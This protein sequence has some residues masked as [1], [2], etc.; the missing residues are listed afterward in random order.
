M[1]IYSGKAR[2]IDRSEEEDVIRLCK[3]LWQENGIFQM[4]DEK[5]RSML[6]RAFDRQGGILAGIGSKG[7]L[8]GLLFLI[9]SNFWYTEDSHWEELF[10]YVAPE[11][12]KSRNAVELLKFAK[13]CVEESGFPLFIGILS[14]HTTERKEML[15]ER[16]LK[17][18]PNGKFF[19]YTGKK[20]K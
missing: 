3:M 12:R 20:D 8:E 10:L 2:I 7:K 17:Q 19:V 9:L 5:V 15:Y 16:Q 14:N 13:W 18:T 11:Y 4:N 6:N 1:T